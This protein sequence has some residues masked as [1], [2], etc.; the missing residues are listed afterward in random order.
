V[1]EAQGGAVDAS[2]VSS[3]DLEADGLLDAISAQVATT[4]T[5]ACW[6][7]VPRYGRFAFTANTPASSISALRIQRDGSLK[8][9]DDDG[10]TV[11]VGSAGRPT[12]LASSY[13]GD[14]LFA[15]SSSTGE[16]YSY[17]IKHN[18]GLVPV[19]VEDNLATTINGLAAF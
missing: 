7:E 16:I 17:R 14:Y 9:R 11:K 4:E 10:V 12:D 19:D 6:V 1:T 8:L 18:G 13:G 15:L 2:T 3:Y 5:A